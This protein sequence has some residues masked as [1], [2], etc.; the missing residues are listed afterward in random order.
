MANL[1]TGKQY[2]EIKNRRYTLISYDRDTM[3]RTGTY[4]GDLV[5][6][7]NYMLLRQDLGHLLLTERQLGIIASCLWDM[8]QILAIVSV[9]NHKR[10]QGDAQ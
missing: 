6:I 7:S 10:R 3:T 1:I 4:T 5:K 8:N 2:N 9:Q